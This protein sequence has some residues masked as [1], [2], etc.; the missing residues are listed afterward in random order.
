MR[1]Y[2]A[3]FA[4][5]ICLPALAHA[6]GPAVG[7]LGRGGILVP[8]PAFPTANLQAAPLVPRLPGALPRI[9][10]PQVIRLQG[11]SGTMVSA[12]L[13]PGR[14]CREA[15]RQ[16]ERGL[17]MPTQLMAA[18][19]RVES[20][21]ADARGV[22]HPWPW[23]INA[24][25]VGGYYE[26]KAAAI[27]AVRA[28]QARG[29]KSIDVGCMQVNLMFHPDAFASLEQAFDPVA[30]ARYAAAF[31]T[32]LYAQT[33][34]WARA[35]ANYH[36]ATPD[37]GDSYQRKVAAVLPE[38]MKRLGD[39]PGGGQPNVWSVN[40]WTANTWNTGAPPAFAGRSGGFMLNNGAH[41]AHIIRLPQGAT[42]RSLAAYRSAPVPMVA[43]R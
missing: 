36:S 35:T 17:A 2:T 6:E 28:L 43:T 12:A 41:S 15:I 18:I 29:V 19:A 31:L 21:R 10:G 4:L 20:G 42:G 32:R 3:L 14:Q 25:G 11:T 34:D 39:S 16:A 8:M 33:H 23:T 40:A 27:A 13:T 5:A 24:E 1:R 30:N 37:L 22:V 38:E 7:R 9:I 26:T